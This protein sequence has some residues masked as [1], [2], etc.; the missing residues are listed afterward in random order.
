LAAD[1]NAEVSH[2]FFDET[3]GVKAPT[4]NLLKINS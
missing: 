1:D 4:E 3:G 2:V